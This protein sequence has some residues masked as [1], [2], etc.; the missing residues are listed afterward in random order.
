MQFDTRVYKGYIVPVMPEINPTELVYPVA[1]SNLSFAE[2]SKLTTMLQQI[3]QPIGALAPAPSRGAMLGGTLTA[4]TVGGSLGLLHAELKEGLDVNGIPVD[5]GL[6]VV[7]KIGAL[8]YK[9]EQSSKVS[10]SAMTVYSFRTVDRV[11]SA[12]KSR[13]A[14]QQKA[15][16]AE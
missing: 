2:K 5:L 9:S 11:L 12:I 13:R 14:E 10:D 16:A 1:Q 8:I 15:Q 7:A 6:A 4:S 3:Q